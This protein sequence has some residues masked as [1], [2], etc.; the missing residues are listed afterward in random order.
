MTGN[1][2]TL[3]TKGDKKS[4]EIK[5]LIDGNKKKYTKIEKVFCPNDPFVL[6]ITAAN[7]QGQKRTFVIGDEK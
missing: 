7:D 4:F 6:W 1:S 3:S 2:K 5:S